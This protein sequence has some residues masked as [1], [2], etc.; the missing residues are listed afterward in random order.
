MGC[1]KIG[2]FNLGSP[3]YL[4]YFMDLKKVSQ[5]HRFVLA[6]AQKWERPRVHRISRSWASWALR[7]AEIGR[8]CQRN[9]FLILH[10][11]K[12]Q[13]TSD[14][15]PTTQKNGSGGFSLVFWAYNTC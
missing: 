1:C 3:H 6:F 15:D 12:S 11:G 5:I 7:A 4:K 2:L 9:T 14:C 8:N 13:L 10:H